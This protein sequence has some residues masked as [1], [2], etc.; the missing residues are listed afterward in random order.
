MGASLATRR[1]LS[2]EN[3][4]TAKLARRGEPT[5]RGLHANMFLVR[6]ARD[7]MEP[8]VVFLDA[9]V[10]LDEFLMRDEHDGAMQHIAVTRQGRI[11]GVLRVNTRIRH[12][13]AQSHGGVTLGEAA[14]KDFTIVRAESAV[15][16]VIGRMTKRRASA[17]LVLARTPGRPAGRLSQIAGIITKEH[18]ADSVADTIELYP[19]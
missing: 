13:L 3:I 14:Q 17:A 12:Q 9:D 10:R 16:D 4:Y 8:R 18:I 15:F 11:V 5:P 2:L 7:I 19:T 1:L 6:R